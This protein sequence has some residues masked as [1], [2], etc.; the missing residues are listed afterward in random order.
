VS[1]VS[2][3]Y[4]GRGNMTGNG[5]SAYGY[6]AENRMISGPNAA[7]LTY[8]PMGRMLQSTSNAGVTKFQY[9]G[10]DLVAEYNASNQLARRYVHGPGDDEPLVWYEGSGTADRRWFHQDERGSTVALTNSAGIT[11]A[12]N[13][14]DEYGVPAAA[15]QG[16]FQYTG[17]TWMADL[18]LY[19]YKARMYSPTLGR[20]MQTDPIGYEDGINWYAYAGNNPTN[21]VDSSGLES[22]FDDLNLT[23]DQYNAQASTLWK[24]LTP[25]S[26][27]YGFKNDNDVA[28]AAA[29]VAKA[30]TKAAV[31]VEST[32][33]QRMMAGSIAKATANAKI[34]GNDQKYE[35]ALTI[36]TSENGEAVVKSIEVLGKQG[37]SLQAATGEAVAHLHYDGLVQPPNSGDYSAAKTGLASFVF[38]SRGQTWEVGRQ[39]GNYVQRSIA[40]DG[41]PGKWK[42][43]GSEK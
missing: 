31:D 3:G 28:K 33:A 38:G 40:S 1:G 18:N 24:S 20:F 9:D 25:P 5:A 29:S 11:A 27:K 35:R 19:Y 13:A 36:G 32:P 42:A 43:F 12:I 16:R 34:G 23:A 30:P 41:T 39:G 14:Y 8:D 26:S 10:T 22:K 2:M 15:N 7:T 37:A 4:D 17:Q 21:R 6:T